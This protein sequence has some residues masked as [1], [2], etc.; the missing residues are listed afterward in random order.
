M[1]VQFNRQRELLKYY[2]SRGYYVVAGGSY[3]SIAQVRSELDLLRSLGAR[4]LFFVDDNFIGNI[5]QARELL[6]AIADYQRE[7]GYPFR[8][9][10]EA[11]L[12]LAQHEDLMRLFNEANFMWVFIG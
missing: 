12:N 4:N 5:P 9:G 6:K 7:H 3:A 10:T 11:S 1:G 8:F 2:R